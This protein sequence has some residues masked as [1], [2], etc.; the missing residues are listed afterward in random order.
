M[1]GKEG[2]GGKSEGGKLN[3]RPRA[4]ELSWRFIAY[5]CNFG[6]NKKKKQINPLLF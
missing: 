5:E 6:K 4:R 3:H 2:G 1:L